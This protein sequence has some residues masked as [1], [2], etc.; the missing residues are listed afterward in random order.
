MSVR[1]VRYGLR[2]L[3]KCV[4]EGRQ[5]WIERIEEVCVRGDRGGLRGL[6]RTF[7]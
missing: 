7:E 2:G 5:M 6:K 1:G 3:K 4:C